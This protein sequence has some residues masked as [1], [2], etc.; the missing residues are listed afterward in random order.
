MTAD[1]VIEGGPPGSDVI[2]GEPD[3]GERPRGRFE[4]DAFELGLA[5]P[6][7]GAIAPAELLVVLPRFAVVD[8]AGVGIR[9]V[10][11]RGVERSCE[12]GEA[13]GGE[14]VVVIDL[15][16]DMASAGLAREL[17]E[18]ADA[19]GLAG[20]GNDPGLGEIDTDFPRIAVGDDDPFEVGVRLSS[21]RAGQTVERSKPLR[22]V[23]RCRK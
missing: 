17:L 13:V 5:V 10:D 15:D 1:A 8:L 7:K 21:N 6:G 18:F 22:V 16:E 19:L 4:R 11:L 2:G 9:E 12:F 23:G 20:V 3:L 14:F